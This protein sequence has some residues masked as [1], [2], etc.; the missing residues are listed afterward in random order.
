MIDND[1]DNEEDWF[2]E[3]TGLQREVEHP[4]PGW[5]EL[6]FW[7]GLWLAVIFLHPGAPG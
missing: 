7:V 2:T 5:L 6:L 4:S 1:N 3:E